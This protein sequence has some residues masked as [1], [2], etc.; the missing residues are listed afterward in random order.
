MEN[1]KSHKLIDP[2]SYTRS[3]KNIRW[4][5]KFWGLHTF[6]SQFFLLC[7]YTSCIFS[8]FLTNTKVRHV[9]VCLEN[10][11]YWF[12]QKTHNWW[13]NK[14]IWIWRRN[15]GAIVP[16]EAFAMTAKSSPSSGTVFFNYNCEFLPEGR[17]VNKKTSPWSYAPFA[18]SN[19]KKRPELLKNKSW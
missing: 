15:Q 12:A 19:T 1:S 5:F 4:I 13:W 7:W 3:S 16:V 2:Y 11:C 9:L 14:G 17:M 6:D 18:W 10:I 8:L